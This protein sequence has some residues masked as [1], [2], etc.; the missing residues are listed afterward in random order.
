MN[1]LKFYPLL[2]FGVSFFVGCFFLLVSLRFQQVY[3]AV[4]YIQFAQDIAAEGFWKC[5]MD[6]EPGYSILIAPLFWLF[7]KS[8]AIMSARILNIFLFSASSVLFFLCLKLIMPRLSEKRLA[9]FCILFALSPQL[10]SFS[11]LRVYSE[12]LQLFLNA[13]ILFCFLKISLKNENS[14]KPGELKFWIVSG[15][16]MSYLIITKAFFIL[17]PFWMIFFI[18]IFRGILQKVKQPLRAVSRSVSIFLILSFLVPVAW[19][20][21]NYKKYGYF[22]VASRGVEVL[23]THA[24]LT[25]WG[26]K[27][28]LKWGVYQLGDNFGKTLFP[29]DAQR[30]AKVTGEPYQ[31]AW[32][33]VRKDNSGAPGNEIS[34]VSE[35]KRLVKEHPFKYALFYCLNALNHVLFEGIYPD[36]YPGQKTILVNCI[37]LVAAVSLHLFY[38]LFI[39]GMI[40]AGI[41]VYVSKNGV[42]FLLRIRPENMIIVVSLGYF[43]FFAYHF[44]TEIRYFHPF[45]INIYLLFALSCGYLLEN[46]LEEQH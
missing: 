30:M 43:L 2:F 16:A 18:L 5:G 17:Y 32:E 19:S 36:I 8:T 39:W 10:A 40:L 26:I 15:L 25:E 1:R 9:V 12:P 46:F 34:A 27:D 31:K 7:S 33:R 6:K 29:H 22:M 44:H 11:A 42:K 20:W 41:F 23:L 14:W 38:S 13:V 3:D 37:Y 35:W 21:R 28:A 45:Y 4:N 24:Y